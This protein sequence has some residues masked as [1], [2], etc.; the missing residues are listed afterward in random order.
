MTNVL[1]EE[2][3]TY[4]S[5]K[6]ELLTTDKG[7]FVLIKRDKVVGIFV[8][9]EDALDRGYREFGRPPFLVKQILEVDPVL[10]M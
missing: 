6:A 1:D 3:R 8:A 4:E 9:E 10:H 7:K 5:H 2:L